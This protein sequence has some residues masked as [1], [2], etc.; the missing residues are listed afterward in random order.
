M[1]R[2][3]VEKFHSILDEL[4]KTIPDSDKITNALDNDLVT[5]IKEFRTIGFT[6][7]RQSGKTTFAKELLDKNKN[8]NY[9]S[10]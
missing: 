3:T 2:K 1:I 8:Y 6:S 5:K 10:Y 7:T 9:V 4:I